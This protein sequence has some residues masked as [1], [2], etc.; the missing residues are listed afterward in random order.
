MEARFRNGIKKNKKN[1]IKK[2]VTDFILQF[3]LFSQ[4]C[5]I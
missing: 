4:N 2:K 3:W 5:E 1:K